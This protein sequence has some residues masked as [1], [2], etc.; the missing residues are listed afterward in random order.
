MYELYINEQRLILCKTEFLS[1]IQSSVKNAQVVPF[2]KSKRKLLAFI[3]QLRNRSGAQTYIMHHTKKKRMIKD[4]ESMIKPI[5]AAGG[6]VMNEE[7]EG[8]F[9][10]KRKRWDLPKGKLNKKE[11]LEE[12]A[13]REVQEETSVSGL[14]LDQFLCTT[15]HVF[16]NKNRLALKVSHWFLMYAPKQTLIPQSEESIERAEWHSV[17]EILEENGSFY[18]NLL[19]VLVQYKSLSDSLNTLPLKTI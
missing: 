8:L 15:R 9:I 5:V 19:N 3:K 16:K 12:G 6:L 4:L 17:D 10:L 11:S 13:L 18:S 7:K 1:E 14:K 2:N